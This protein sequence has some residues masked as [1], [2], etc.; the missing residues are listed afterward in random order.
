MF[1]V[2]VPKSINYEVAEDYFKQNG[3]DIRPMFYSI[4]NHNHLKT[5]ENVKSCID[6]NANIL[7][8]ECFILPSF[9]D[10]TEN[11]VNYIICKVNNFVKGISK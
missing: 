5:N 11:E 2:R 1:G 9:P 6:I 7:Q 3:I 10:L 4:M 8:K